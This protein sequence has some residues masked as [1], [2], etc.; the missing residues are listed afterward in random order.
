MGYLFEFVLYPR[1]ILLSPPYFI[2][3]LDILLLCQIEQ[4]VRTYF[5]SKYQVAS[6]QNMESSAQKQQNTFC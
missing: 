2:N 4:I 5:F 6:T 3:I 1:K